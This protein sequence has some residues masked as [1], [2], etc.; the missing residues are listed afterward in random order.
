MAE[1]SPRC[2]KHSKAG[3]ML[4]RV[5]QGA[6]GEMLTW[7]SWGRQR[8]AGVRGCGVKRQG[9]AENTGAKRNPGCHSKPRLEAEKSWR[10]GKSTQ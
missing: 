9:R 5:P 8:T 10:K 3:D 7:G 2:Q 1:E 6:S 4:G